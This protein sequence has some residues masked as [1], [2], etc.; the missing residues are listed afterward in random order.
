VNNVVRSL[1][2]SEFSYNPGTLS[3]QEALAIPSKEVLEFIEL[4]N[5]DPEISINLQG[6]LVVG[7]EFTFGSLVLGPREFVVLLRQGQESL[8]RVRFPFIDSVVR[9]FTGTLNNVQESL[10]LELNGFRFFIVNYS[11]TAPW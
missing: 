7:V 6:V 10:A 1:R 3:A 11:N 9:T 8:T 4:Y 5:A 2:I